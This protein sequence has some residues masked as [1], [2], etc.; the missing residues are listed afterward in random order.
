M[1][2]IN[3]RKFAKTD[4]EMVSSLFTQGTTAMGFYKIRKRGILFLNLQKQP[5]LYLCQNVVSS[6]FFVSCSE[7]VIDGKKRIRYMHS[8]C[9]VDEQ[10]V[11]IDALSHMQQHDLCK[12]IQE[13]Q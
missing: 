3:G 8:T 7:V 2:V 1:I 12:S 5:F 13:V 10:K 6:P 4:S 11:G 9:S